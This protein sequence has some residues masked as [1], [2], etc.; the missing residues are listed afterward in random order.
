MDYENLIVQKLS[1]SYCDILATLLLNNLTDKAI[2]FY[3]SIVLLDKRV[4]IKVLQEF[5]ELEE[6]PVLIEFI[7]GISSS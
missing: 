5:T 2:E 7:A 1:N 4:A 6:K 3:K